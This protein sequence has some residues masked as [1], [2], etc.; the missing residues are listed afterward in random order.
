MGKP[1]NMIDEDKQKLM[2]HYFRVHQQKDGGWGTHIESPSTMFGTV[3]IYV[4]LR[5]LGANP[6]EDFMKKGRAFIQNEGGAIFTSSWAKFW[7]CLLGA[8]DYKGV[9]SIPPEM[10]L[11][12]NWF[13]FHP[14]RLWCH[15]RM[16]YLPM[17]YLYGS[18]FV[19]ENASTD[20]LIQELRKELYC[21]PYESIDWDKTRF[22]VADMD[23]YSP[24][25]VVMRLA[26]DFLAIYERLPLIQ[27]LKNFIRKKGLKFCKG[28]IAAED[29]QTNF[30]DIGPVN[31]V[32]NMVSAFHAANN[33]INHTTIQNHMMRIPDY[34]WLAEDGMKMQGYNGS[35]CWDT[36]FAIQ[37]I[38][39]C[40]LLDEF[41]DVSAKVW[42]YLER[43]QI[44]STEVSQS[45]DAFRYESRENRDLFYRHV[46]KGGWPFSTSAHGWPISDCTGEGLKG[47]C[48][49]LKSTHILA[50]IE[51]GELLKINEARLQDAVNVVLTFQNEDGG[52]SLLAKRF[53]RTLHFSIS[54]ILMS[55][56]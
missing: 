45:S 41:P 14:G 36:S 1:S 3:L 26:Q 42:S 15:C 55:S 21:Q 35:Q 49:L 56:S 27:P 18:K 28:Y 9:N 17:G 16:V 6:E 5:L 44:L 33:D 31:K 54:F 2:S 52:R 32:L 39:E 38:S 29:L 13:P 22:L 10:W 19:Y 24:L 47:V 8:Y 51:K 34:L 25:P 46:S 37:A 43:T 23:N 53:L 48:A 40:Q 50:G 4:S 30:I 12:P 11:L 20:P 7:L